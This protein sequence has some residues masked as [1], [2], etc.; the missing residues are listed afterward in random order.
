MGRYSSQLAPQMADLAGVTKGQRVLDVGSGPGALTEELVRRLGVEQ[1]AAID[2]SPSFVT[3]VAERFPGVD[4]RQG[5]AEQLPYDD[6][7]FDVAIAQLVVHFMNDPVSGLKEMRRVT[8]RGGVVAACVWDHAGLRS[9][10]GP[11]WRAAHRFD[12]DLDDEAEL[13]GARQGQLV[14]LMEAAGV[15]DITMRTL[16]VSL[17][18]DT[19]DDWWQPFTLGV[20]PAGKYVAGLDE[21]R[22]ELIRELAREDLGEPPFTITG[23]AWAA[24][25]EA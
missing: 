21:E 10:M 22:R 17:E 23:H 11:F 1:V 3:A 2:P 24:R 5:S 13:P 6:Q 7:S 18:H 16:T 4:A 19:F 14:E 8:Q 9:P 15:R 12:P 20:G 25:G